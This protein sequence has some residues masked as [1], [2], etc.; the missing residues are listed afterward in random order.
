MAVNSPDSKL[1]KT[2]D[3]AFQ[4]PIPAVRQLEK[5]LRSE[6]ANNQERLRTLVGASYRDLLGTAERIVEMDGTMQQVETHLGVISQK[7]NS[8][9]LD[10]IAKSYVAF[11]GTFKAQGRF[12]RQPTYNSKRYTFASQLAVLQACPV[13]ISRLLREGVS[14]LLA[15]KILVISRLLHKD[16]SQSSTTLSLVEKLRNQLAS[17]RRHLLHHIDRQFSNPSASASILIEA[18]C[19]F[20]L[21]TSSSPTDVMRHFTHVRLQAIATQL[22]RN[23]AKHS[24]TLKALKLYIQ[25]LLD[26]QAVLPDRLA[27]SLV[28]LK[29]HPLLKDPEVRAAVELN[30]DIH[31]KWISDDI[32]VFTPWVR[33]DDLHKSQASV[34]LREWS[35]RAFSTLIEGLRRCLSS[36]EDFRTLVKLRTDILEAWLNG[37]N[38]VAGF[39]SAES[40]ERLR[41]V[42]N[43]RLLGLIRGRTHCLRLVG[44]QVTATL[45]A[46][47]AGITDAREDLWSSSTASMDIG[48]GATEFKSTVLDRLHGRNDAVLGVLHGYQAWLKTILE[49]SVVVKELRGQKWDGDVD[50]VEDEVDLESRV[51]Q[52][53]GDDPKLLEDEL[54]KTLTTE[55]QDLHN[56]ISGIAAKS[57]QGP[58]AVFLLR[59]LREIRQQAPGPGDTDGFG[60]SIIPVLHDRVVETASSA[61]LSLFECLAS[62]TGWGRNAPTRALWEGTPPLPIQPSLGVFNLLHGLTTSMAERGSDIWSSTAIRKLKNHVGQR[63]YVVLSAV[64]APVNPSGELINGH[65]SEETSEASGKEG[66]DRPPASTSKDWTTQLLFDVFFLETVLSTTTESGEN[67][68]GSLGELAQTLEEKAGITEPSRER[69]RKA[70]QEYWKRTYLLFS[71][72][73]Q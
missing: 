21:A 28:R 25:T 14:S 44:A 7:C 68:I 24:N 71:F 33:H 65:G 6:L 66:L 39:V 52:L 38:R 60:L 41:L 42:I 54:G 31:D 36:V 18:M 55:F 46:W 64:L 48:D 5:Q 10:R 29:L 20:S 45:Q 12:H 62:N 23:E 67:S 16:L 37:S 56:A 19:A 40:L 51:V 63:I 50:D 30:L 58:Q 11:D 17:L 49:I 53:S 43:E 59:I 4:H 9:S 13:V 35:K 47:K 69:L 34:L 26:T 72:L 32:R 73:A 22:D 57:E 1:L 70:T 2:W 8:R 15:A 27:E 3:D 61:S